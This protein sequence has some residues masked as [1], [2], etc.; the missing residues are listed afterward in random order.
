METENQTLQK[1]NEY[2]Q[3]IVE[4]LSRDIESLRIKFDEINREKEMFKQKYHQ[5]NGAY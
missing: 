4:E 5:S 1:A 3:D 2:Y